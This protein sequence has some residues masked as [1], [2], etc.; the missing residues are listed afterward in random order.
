MD[1]I[2]G[3]KAINIFEKELN[4]DNFILFHSTTIK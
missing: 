2:V 3:K 1:S 4:E